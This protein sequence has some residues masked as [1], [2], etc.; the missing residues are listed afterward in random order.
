MAAFPAFIGGSATGQSLIAESERTVNLYVE[1]PSGKGAKNPDG[2]LF[3][4]PGFTAW[5][6]GVTDVGSRALAVADGRLFGV[7]GN[8]LWE[9]ASNGAATSRGAVVQDSIPAQLIYNGKVG[10]QLGIKSGGNIYSFTLATNVFAGP[11]FGGVT[12]TMLQYA[13]GYGLAF[14]QTTGKV[15]LSSLNDF[16]TWSAGNFFQRSKFPDPW[17]TMFV[18]PNG[19]IWLLGSETF[20]VWYDTGSGTQ[21]WAPLSGLYGR[22]GIAAPWAF[23]VTGAGQAWLATSAEG[24]TEIVM[25]RGGAPVSASTYAV[26]TAISNYRRTSQITDAEMLAYDEDG[27]SFISCSFPSAGGTWTLDA[28]TKSWAERGQWNSLTGVFDVWAP[29]C[30]ADCFGK[31]LIGDRTTGTIWIMSNDVTTEIDGTG[32]RRLRR[33]A[34]L[35]DE[36]KRH[37]IDRFE[38]LMDVGL[39]TVSGQGSNPL[40]M[41]RVSENGGRTWSNELTASI[42]R[43]GEYRKR[44]YWDQLGAPEDFVVEVSWTDPSPV[45][46]TG[47]WI[48][49]LEGQG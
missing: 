32:I 27:H 25:S 18:D 10:G 21:P 37:P 28:E 9:F 8:H 35:T 46:V 49:N 22:N 36:H 42:G 48:N 2:A 39:G 4:V 31:H 44:V 23:S 12:A 7:V 38:I 6:S 11:H 16:T 47:A 19:L 20:E 41:L 15:F 5:S 17:Q 13:D 14:E 43:M 33:T 26:N 45:R 24:G 29:R 30:H 34:G 1:L 3:P 40:A